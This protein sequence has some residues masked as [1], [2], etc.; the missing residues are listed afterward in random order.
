MRR[1]IEGQR[2]IGL[3]RSLSM[4]GRILSTVPTS[5]TLVTV[6]YNN[7][8]KLRTYWSTPIPA[9]VEWIVVDNGST[10]DSVAVARELGAT[11]VIEAG[12]NLGFSAANNVG[13]KRSTGTY[14]AF[15]NPDVRV[16]F[17]D[18][19]ALATRI[20]R[21]GGL[22]SPQLV[23]DDLSRQPNGRGMPLLLHKV[24]NR[25]SNGSK[26]QDSYLL[27]A[28]G[29]EERSVFWLIGA[30]VAGTADTFAALG[31]WNERY[32]LYYEDKDISIRAW[33]AGLPVTLCGQF[34]WTHGWAR[35]TTSFKLAPWARE[36]SSLLKF[37]ALYPEFVL[38]GEWAR[39]RN[40]TAA[41]RSG[42]VLAID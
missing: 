13:L 35:E 18:L 11:H 33:R 6:T 31:G 37:Y 28:G 32:F 24:L 14:V 15:V 17:E 1:L 4:T 19:P 30:V 8:E 26:L 23:N 12:R 10:D 38:G 34:R 7:A 22:V 29:N 21:R 25:L 20:N 39:A 2:R 3:W 42:D 9:G 41:M 5:W 16:T 27:F 40:K 36:I